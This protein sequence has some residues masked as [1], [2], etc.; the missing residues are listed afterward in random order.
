MKTLIFTI[1]LVLPTLGMSQGKT[2]IDVF[3]SEEFYF[4]GYDFTEFR[5]IDRERIGR[6]A[7]IKVD[8]FWITAN[9]CTNVLNLRVVNH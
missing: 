9:Y 7:E 2:L 8:L 3:N 4:Y 5:L 1:L 6:G